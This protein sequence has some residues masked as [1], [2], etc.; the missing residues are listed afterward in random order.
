MNHDNFNIYLKKICWVLVVVLSGIIWYNI[1]YY[2]YKAYQMIHK[3]NTIEF[4][5]TLKLKP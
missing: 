4:R 1:G 2:A 3:N 5:H